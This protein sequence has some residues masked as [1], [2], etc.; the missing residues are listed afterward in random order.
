MR[1]SASAP[2][3]VGAVGAALAA[4]LAA[5][6]A[7]ADRLVVRA[8]ELHTAVG[9]PQR[10]FAVVIEDGRIARV[11][12]AAGFEPPARVPVYTAHSVTPGL[13]DVH[14][15]AGLAGL[16][17]VAA[18]RDQDET[19][20][21]NQAGLRA[22]DA[23]NPRE[24]LLRYLLEQGVTVVQSGPG[25]ANPVGGQMGIF[26]TFGAVADTMAIRFPSALSFSLGEAPKRT[27]AGER[28]APGTRMATAAVIRTALTE[29]REYARKR[30][31]AGSSR[32][33]DDRGA[34]DRD[35]RLEPLARAL[36]RELP[37][38]FVGHRSDDLM[39]ALRI[40]GEFDLRAALAGASEAYLV[41]DRIRAAGVPVFVGPVMTRV[42]ALETMNASYQ[43]A[44]I[45][46]DRGVMIAI[47]S[48]FEPYVP[49][50]R[51]VRL[52]AAVAAANE[53]GRD[54]ALRA[55][56]LDA[57]RFLEIDADYG[58]LEPGKVADL[59]LYDG[60]PFEYTTHVERVIAAGAVVYEGSSG[61]GL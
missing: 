39:T 47:R 40:A 25:P 53:L 56:T 4:V 55:I 41:A 54:R 35:L 42:G 7:A 24:P 49:R 37:V 23:F 16:Y 34:P 5:L 46:A 2:R 9:P 58:S 57:A 60:D 30:A 44:A 20:E 17:N 61:S 14:T 18:D 51:V 32:D 43:N 50:A 29:A 48:G 15:S 28:K 6:P 52:E 12:E 31:E 8:E 33:R 10:D 27:Y 26:R 1:A 45:L 22:I 11:V 59:V 36:A 38:V 19:S 3:A 13:I 21:P